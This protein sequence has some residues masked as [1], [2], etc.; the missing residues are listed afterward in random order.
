MTLFFIKKILAKYCLKTTKMCWIVP[1]NSKIPWIY[2][3]VFFFVICNRISWFIFISLQWEN[4]PFE[5]HCITMI[6]DGKCACFKL[7]KLVRS[8]YFGPTTDSNYYS[9]RPFRAS[10]RCA[11]YVTLRNYYF[12]RSSLV[13]Y[14]FQ[15]HP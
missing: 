12:S 8:I 6:I 15:P 11:Q 10:P 1:K 14:F 2:L 13:M 9:K 5:E 7:E 3:L 4:S